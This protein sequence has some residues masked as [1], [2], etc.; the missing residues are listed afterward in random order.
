MKRARP[1]RKT[2]TK[3]AK[4]TES[5]EVR[6]PHAV[7][8]DFMARAQA[9]GRTASAVLREF[10]DAYLAGAIPSEERSMLKRL[11]TPAAATAVIA[12]VVA[13]HVMIPTAAS[14]APNFKSVFDQL[15][16][17]KDGKLSAAELAGHPLLADEAYSRHQA[18]LGHGAVP[19]MVAVHSGLQRLVHG[20]ATPE[21]RAHMEATFASLDGD[22]N[23]T[24]TF[25][26]F[27]SHHLAV[28]RH[29]FDEIDADQDGRIAPAELDAA[30]A[31][32]PQGAATAH[33]VSFAQ[34]DGNRDGGISWEEFL[35]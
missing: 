11:A 23:G 7:K 21:M 10:I 19:I 6:V 5:L 32:M 25:G 13:A 17:D 28:L 8:R 29:A 9:R 33:L 4:K 18:D 27:E 34:L 22:K 31:H 35:G 26:E 24:V 1:P 12:T 3:S 20:P 14:A 15:D 2:A 30:M 16:R